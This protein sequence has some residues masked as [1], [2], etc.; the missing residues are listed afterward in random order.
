MSV[1]EICN[2]GEIQFGISGD[3]RG[4]SKVLSTIQFI[5]VLKNLQLT[6]REEDGW[7]ILVPLVG[8]DLWFARVHENI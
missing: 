3:E 8:G 7:G 1:E 2:K 6:L 5:C 4:G